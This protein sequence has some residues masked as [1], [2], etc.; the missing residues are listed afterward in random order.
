MNG[1]CNF[2]GMNWEHLQK[3]V[4]YRTSRSGGAGGQH[5]NKVSTKVEILFDVNGSSVLSDQQKSIILFKLKN[6]ITSNNTLTLT[7]DTTRS[8]LKNKEIAFDR[9][10]ELMT[11]A[12]VPVKKRRPT[13]PSK[14]SVKKRLK[15]KK[16]QSNKKDSRK[17]NPDKD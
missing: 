11:T 14:S 12:L 3:E 9:L 16:I 6:R 15:S 17:F 7:C 13:K 2:V 1:F 4:K 8:Q 10:I 5:V